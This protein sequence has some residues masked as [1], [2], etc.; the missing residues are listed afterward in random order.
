MPEYD[1]HVPGEV[2]SVSSDEV[3]LDLDGRIRVERDLSPGTHFEFDGVSVTTLERPGEYLCSVATT[4]DVHFGETVCGEVVG[5]EIGP[6]FR[7]GPD[8]EPYPS[9]MNRHAV[10]EILRFEPAAMVVKGDLTDQGRPYEFDAFLSCYQTAF[11]DRLWFVRGNHDC[12]LTDDVPGSQPLQVIEVEGA[13][14]ILL[15]TSRPGLANGTLSLAQLEEL[16]EL[17]RTA[18]CPVIVLGHHPIWDEETQPRQ[19]DVF[20]LLP[21]PSEHLIDIVG[22]R[23][24][25]VTYAAGHTHRNRVIERYGVPFVEV[26][27]VKEF[28]GA[29]CEYQIFDGGILQVTRRILN[30]EAR[31]WSD[32][33]K[34]MFH[35]HFEEYSWGSLSERCRILPDRS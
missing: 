8:E 1:C 6:V 27:S 19:D 18:D 14:I 26:A 11:G 25:I 5:T 21:D 16:D 32:K 15:D 23:P 34:Q 4:N 10:E 33:T 30:D 28:P 24:S 12:A 9:M 7:S 3:V 22:R 17:A 31:A 2:L 35:G 29:W 20:S 13:M